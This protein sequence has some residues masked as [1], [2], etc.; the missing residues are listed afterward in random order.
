MTRE[1]HNT[2][3]AF[4]KKAVAT[5][6]ITGGLL[7]STQSVDALP[8][9]T[10]EIQGNGGT[11]NYTISVNTTNVSKKS[12]MDGDEELRKG[13]D[14]TIISGTIGADDVDKFSVEGNITDAY[15]TGDV[16]VL[17]NGAWGMNRSGTLTVEGTNSTYLVEVTDGLEKKSQTESSEKIS[18]GNQ[19]GVNDEVSG[20]LG[21]SDTDVF[22]GN[23]SINA[24]YAYTPDTGSYV[25]VS[26]DL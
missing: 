8:T 23:G 19:D 7:A 10:L 15:L 20:K 13:S 14:S 22:S 21:W 11:S 3:R 17:M 9:P 2:R 6:G 18:D 12:G 24:I 4:M 16:W 26:Q 1:K 5:A 25:D